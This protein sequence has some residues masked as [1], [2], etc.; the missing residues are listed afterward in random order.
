M[1]INTAQLIYI[2]LY[3]FYL[4]KMSLS[5]MKCSKCI[6]FI[7]NHKI[8][9]Y[10]FLV[11]H[12]NEISQKFMI[13]IC[14]INYQYACRIIIYSQNMEKLVNMNLCLLLLIIFQAAIQRKYQHNNTLVQNFLLIL[15]YGFLCNKSLSILNNFDKN[16]IVNMVIKLSIFWYLIIF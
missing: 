8:N 13:Y 11:N 16:N 2:T 12:Y 14:H 3:I 4:I 1:P 6:N 15:L 7:N 5:Q 9:I 10:H